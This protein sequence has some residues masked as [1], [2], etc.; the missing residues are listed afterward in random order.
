VC[1]FLIPVYGSVLDSHISYY[2]C[3]SCSVGGLLG[4]Y[5]YGTHT[6]LYI[7]FRDSGSS[8]SDQRWHLACNSFIQRGGWALGILCYNSIHRCIWLVFCFLRQSCFYGLVLG[9]VLI[10]LEALYMWLLSILWF[11][12]K[13]CLTCCEAFKQLHLCCF[14]CKH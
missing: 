9:L 6:T 13:F 11:K 14:S 8:I 2:F 4:T 12:D 5:L 10:L 7:S 3:F 1:I